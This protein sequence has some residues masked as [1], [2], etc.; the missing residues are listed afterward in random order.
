MLWLDKLPKMLGAMDGGEQAYRDV[1]TAVFGSLSSHGAA[2]TNVAAFKPKG[3]LKPVT[4][5]QVK[6]FRRETQEEACQSNSRLISDLMMSGTFSFL[7]CGDFY[8]V[9]GAA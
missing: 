8:P 5:S 1:F 9:W 6:G 2:C 4:N 3:R 7:I